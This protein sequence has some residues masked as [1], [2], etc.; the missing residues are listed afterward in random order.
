MLHFVGPALN[1]INWIQQQGNAYLNLNVVLNNIL[2]PA[3]KCVFNVQQ[4]YKT[5]ENVATAL[6]VLLVWAII[7]R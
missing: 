2:T 1:H 7:W 4:F 6:F 5:V 3:P